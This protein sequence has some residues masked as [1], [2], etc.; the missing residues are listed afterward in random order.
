M[1]HEIHC[2]MLPLPNRFILAQVG[3][4]QWA[5]PARVI[6]NIATA[7]YEEHGWYEECELEE[8]PD[9]KQLHGRELRGHIEV[10]GDLEHY[11]K[12]ARWS[13]VSR[14]AKLLA[15]PRVVPPDDDALWWF[16]ESGGSVREMTDLS[17]AEQVPNRLLWFDEKY[18]ALHGITTE[19]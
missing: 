18:K 3:E 6:L 19:G 13:E 2:G 5:I 17:P 9:L 16:Q 1:L 4:T 12:E 14:R 10:N 11:A 8:D 15:G 7:Y